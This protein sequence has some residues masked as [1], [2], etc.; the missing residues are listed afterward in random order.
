[1]RFTG[2]LSTVAPIN[3]VKS[4]FAYFRSGPMVPSMF[5]D[6][7][8]SFEDCNAIEIV[9]RGDGRGYILNVQTDSMQPEDLYQSFVYTRGGPFWQ[10]IRIPVVSTAC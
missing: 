5:G 8:M 9:V 6:T 10:T 3:A 2:S 7:Y 1:M 4:G